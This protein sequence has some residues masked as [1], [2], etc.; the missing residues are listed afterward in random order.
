MRNFH[1]YRIKT[2]WEIDDHKI[3]IS[4]QEMI[5]DSQEIIAESQ[6]IN[7]DSHFVGEEAAEAITTQE[8]GLSQQSCNK[9]LTPSQPITKVM[10]EKE[11]D[12]DPVAI[13]QPPLKV[14]AMASDGIEKQK[15][16]DLI[17]SDSTINIQADTVGQPTNIDYHAKCCDQIAAIAKRKN[18]IGILSEPR[19]HYMH[20]HISL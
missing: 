1:G 17:Q 6:E 18:K 19:K 9:D 4:S 11:E 20:Q 7:T 5:T 8:V 10:V 14:A 2:Y 12:I 13:T 16:E 3:T 15:E